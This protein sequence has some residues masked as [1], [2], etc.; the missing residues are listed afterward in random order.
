[1]NERSATSGTPAT[2]ANSAVQPVNVLLVDDQPARMLSYRAILEPLN[3]HLIEA[4]S[5]Q[6]ALRV[7]METDCAM[8]LL[9]VNMPGMDGFETAS[10]IHQHPRYEK[11]PIIFV[12]AVNVSDMDRLQGYK[13]GAVDYVM[14]PII[15]EILRGKVLVLAELHRKRR[16]LEVA[17]LQL[18]E[19]N[20]AL[21]AEKMRELDILNESLRQANAGLASSNSALH[22][23]V[24]E[25]GRIEARLRA[26]DRNKDEFLATLAHELRNPLASLSNAVHAQK[27]GQAGVA[28]PLTDTMQRQVSLLVRLIDD[29]MDVARIAQDKLVLQR[30]ATTLGEV[31]DAA[32]EVVHPLLEAGRHAVQVRQPEA[33]IAL[34]V[35]PARLAQVFA[36]LLNNAA[37]YSDPGTP[38][39]IEVW[40]DARE[41]AVAV[42]DH[43]IGLTSSDAT[44]VFERFRQVD[45]AIERSQGGLGIGLSLV[46][47]IAE[48]HGG[49]VSVVSAGLGEGTRFTVYLPVQRVEQAQTAA[50]A[51]PSDP[52]ESPPLRVLVVDDNRDSADTLALLLGMLGHDVSRCYDPH[53]VEALANAI[54]PD[55]V[56]LDLGMPGLS[57]YDVARQLRRSARGAA[58]RL[59]AMTGWGQPED[60]RRTSEAGFDAHLVKPV[61]AEALVG[62]IANWSQPDD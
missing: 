9:D 58:L 54:A 1:M 36:N 46:K 52:V 17:N 38:I 31:L 21:Q 2:G 48:L 18:E 62:L 41:I 42:I 51:P 37:K 53:E 25:R 12:S 39:E 47:R 49:R 50:T 57:G 34:W 13:L 26:Q 19:A 56:L 4:T 6:D 24:L 40:Q 16:A 28:D 55:L 3:E 27:M 33:P 14:V 8:I 7:L 35:D 43:G 30:K 59:V 15:P 23:E 44:T 29:L 61:D 11:T 32:R 5:G 10:L 22:L 45:A 60:F 20:I